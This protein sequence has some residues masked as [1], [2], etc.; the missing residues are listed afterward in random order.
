MW[1]VHWLLKNKSRRT[2]DGQR[3]NFPH[4]PFGYI[5]FYFTTNIAG[6]PI[7]HIHLSIWETL[8]AH[9]H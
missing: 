8:K 9:D 7:S 3:I 1:M 6:E 2:D 5:I 4:I